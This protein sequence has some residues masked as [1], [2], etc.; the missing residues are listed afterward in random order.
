M[1]CFCLMLLLLAAGWW[2][3]AD[4]ADATQTLTI[5]SETGRFDMTNY[6]TIY[7]GKVR[8]DDPRMHLTSDWLAADLPH[9]KNPD[10]RVVATTNVLMELIDNKGQTNHTT[11]DQAI[12]DL[13]VAGGVTN[14]TVTLSG[15]AK[16]WNDKMTVIGEPLIYDMV[17]QELVGGS[18]WQTTFSHDALNSLSGTNSAGHKTNSVPLIPG[19]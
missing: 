7:M 14:E 19:L 15:H 16:M 6:R 10:S 13:H 12:Y 3:E 8:A 17:K 2:A 18:N 1:K 9:D 5:H 11:S 4:P